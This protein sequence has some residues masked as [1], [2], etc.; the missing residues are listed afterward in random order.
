MVRR[1]PARLPAPFLQTLYVSEPLDGKTGY[2]FTL[3]FFDANFELAFRD[4]VTILVGENGTA[5][6]KL[7]QSFARDPGAFVA[8][9]MDDMAAKNRMELNGNGGEDL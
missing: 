4:P 1:K 3:L 7:Y 5:H 6:F 8:Q 2:L 9:A